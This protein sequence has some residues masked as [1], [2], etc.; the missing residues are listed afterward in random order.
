MTTNRSASL[1]AR[2]LNIAKQRG[3]DDNLMLNRFALERSLCRIAASPHADR[4]LLKG[5]LLFAFWYDEP[6]R[7]K[8]DADLLGFGADA[9]ATLIS[10]FR[11]IAAIEMDD[12][13]VFDAPSLRADA[14][15]EDT[16]LPVV[17]VNWGGAVVRP[18]DWGG[19]VAS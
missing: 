7:P 18:G 19:F 12:G 1:L 15:R 17:L 9:A 16:P 11:E 2:L 14:I 10:T 3:D 6:R 5:A 4:F 13:I 8:C